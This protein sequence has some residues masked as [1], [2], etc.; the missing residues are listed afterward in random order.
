MCFGSETP[1]EHRGWPVPTAQPLVDSRARRLLQTVPS[2]RTDSGEDPALGKPTPP[3]PAWKGLPRPL[4]C[5]QSRPIFSLPLSSSPLMSSLQA[6]AKR[7]LQADELARSLPTA[8]LFYTEP[9]D[10]ACPAQVSVQ[11][12]TPNAITKRDSC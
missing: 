4:A 2:V 12:H 3:S 9:R 5:K 6:A 11:G 10:T 8:F 1:S 7:R